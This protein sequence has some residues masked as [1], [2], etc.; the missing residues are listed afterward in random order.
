MR[1][2]YQYENHGTGTVENG[3]G[4]YWL[5]QLFENA[6]FEHVWVKTKVNYCVFDK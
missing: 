1:L 2:I 6:D 3:K 5:H 4:F